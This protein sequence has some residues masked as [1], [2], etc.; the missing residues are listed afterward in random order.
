MFEGAHR[1]VEGDRD[2][3]EQD[4]RRRTAAASWKFSPQFEIRWPMPVR[5]AYISAII[6]PVKLKIIEMRSVSRRIGIM[7]GHVDAREDLHPR[8]AIGA[9]D[10]HVVGLDRFDRRGR[11]HDDDEQ[12]RESRLGD[13]LLEADPHDQDEHRQ[14]IDFGTLNT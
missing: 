7:L 8:G 6:T 10:Q 11:A 5:E 1:L 13:L 14:K 12:R 2:R 3:R 4:Q 9:R